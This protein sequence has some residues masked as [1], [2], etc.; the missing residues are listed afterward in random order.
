VIGVRPEGSTLLV[1]I[2]DS[3][4]KETGKA[5]A[6]LI[7]TNPGWQRMFSHVVPDK[8]AGW[9]VEA[10]F[11]VMNLRETG[12]PGESGF[13]EK[14]ALWRQKCFADH[15][16]EKSLLCA[17]IE[18]GSI[19]GKHP[20]NGEWFDDLHDETNT[21]SQAEMRKVTDIV[22]A[23]IIPTWTSAGGSPTIGVFCTPWSEDP[24]D[25][26]RVMLKTGIFEHI[27]LPIFVPD[28][29]GEIFPPTGRKVKVAWPEKYPMERIVGIWNRNPVHFGQMYLCDLESLKGSVLKKEWLAEYPHELIS[30]TWPVYL[31]VDVATL[32][33]QVKPGA[34]PDYMV[35]MPARAIP[36]GGMVLVPGG[37]RGRVT[38]DDGLLKIQFVADTFPTLRLIGIERFSNGKDLASSLMHSTKLPIVMYPFD[39]DRVLSKGQKFQMELAPL[40][41]T[42]RMWISSQ[43]DAV[44]DEFE[45]EWIGWDGEKSI[46]K[47]D[48]TLDAGYGVAYIGQGH[49]MPRTQG[50]IPINARQKRGLSSP[51]SAHA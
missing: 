42:G 30:P 48:D 2:N 23:N 51:W 6:E 45:N 12:N 33:D 25:A 28:E 18:S 1:R 3:A 35:I 13:A 11:Q 20:S 22:E 27:K 15:V 10:G 19:I 8:D 36:G 46:T 31:A 39:K 4:A 17:G 44:L 49:L 16:A 29:E 26:Y 14:Y 5:I 43:K 37:F 24:P 41:T 34:D 47:H 38:F 50:D 40:F 9:S 21:R 7:E 32:A